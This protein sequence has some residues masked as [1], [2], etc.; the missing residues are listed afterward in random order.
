MNPTTLRNIAA[1]LQAAPIGSRELD[2]ECARAM[3][4]NVTPLFMGE[5]YIQCEPHEQ[6]FPT[7]HPALKICPQWTTSLD[8]SRALAKELLSEWWYHSGN[9]Y[10]GNGFA[11]IRGPKYPFPETTAATEPLACVSAIL[12]ALAAK[13]EGE[14][15]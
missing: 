8:A 3:D 15:K 12:L 6:E 14:A 10:G 13:I 4:I 11:C 1:K 9:S 2:A 7:P 5:P